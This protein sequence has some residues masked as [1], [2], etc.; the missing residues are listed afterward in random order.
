MEQLLHYLYGNT[1][2]SLLKQLKTADG[3]AVEVIDSGLYN[4]NADPDFFNAKGKDWRHIMG[5]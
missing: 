5:W 4:H 3:E 1:R 2:C